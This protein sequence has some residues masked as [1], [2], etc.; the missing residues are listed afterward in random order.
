MK[1]LVLEKEFQ[2]VKEFGSEFLQ[3]MAVEISPG[4]T[5]K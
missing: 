5:G 3:K 2:Q 4:H 1:H